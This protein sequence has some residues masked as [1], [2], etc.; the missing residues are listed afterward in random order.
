MI[1]TAL[2]HIAPGQSALR[3]TALPPLAPGWVTVQTLHSAISRGTEA[4]VLAGRVP[5]ALHATMRAPFQEGEFSFPVKYGYAATGRIVEG[6]PERLGETVFCLYPHQDCFRVPGEA[7]ITLPAN[8][9]PARAVLAANL[10]TALNA[11]WDAAPRI[12]DTIAIVGGGLVGLLLARLIQGIPAVRLTVIEPDPAKRA[13]AA[14]LGL[15]ARPDGQNLPDDHTLVFHTSATADGLALALDLAA[16]EAEIIEL[17]WYGDQTPA[18]PLG[19]R[20]HARRLRIICSQVGQVASA[21]RSRYTHRQRLALA[22]ALLADPA[23]DHLVTG[24]CAFA[25]L[26]TLLPALARDGRAT[27]CHR[28]DYPTALLEGCPCLP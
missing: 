23:W 3:P 5:P 20:F 22:L 4:L 19:E 8:V 24:Q 28:V 2:W 14:T 7:A 16:P 12:G 6:P 9:P 18:V 17:S 11:C 15:D 26:P 10:E 1:A 21:R 27:L 25:D 13:L